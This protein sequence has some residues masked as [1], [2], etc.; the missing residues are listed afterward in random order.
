M[1]YEDNQIHH[2]KKQSVMR[3]MDLCGHLSYQEDPRDPLNI[4]IDPN[5]EVLV[6]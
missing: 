5:N 1:W 4:I 2:S 3:E 6:K